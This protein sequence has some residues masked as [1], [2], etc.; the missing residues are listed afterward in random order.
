MFLFFYIKE[1][2]PSRPLPRKPSPAVVL[3]ITQRNQTSSTS[4]NSSLKFR[5]RVYYQ[6]TL[7]H[8]SD[9]PAEAI[10]TC[11][12]DLLISINSE[13]SGYKSSPFKKQFSIKLFDF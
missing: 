1:G 3:Y 2:G 4:E 5:D 11:R 7:C 9:R 6:L 10:K 8:I 13:L 12:S